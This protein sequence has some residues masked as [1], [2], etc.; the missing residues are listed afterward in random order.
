ML[1]TS[2]FSIT[3]D[4]FT[5]QKRANF[6]L[7]GLVTLRDVLQNIKSGESPISLNFITEC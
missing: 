3:C 4:G 5:L 2:L 1:D 7:I 6:S